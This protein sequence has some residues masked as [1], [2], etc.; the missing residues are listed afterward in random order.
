S[1]HIRVLGLKESERLL[2]PACGTGGFLVE[3]LNYLNKVFHDEKNVRPG[4]EDTQEFISLR[5]R[6]AD[7]AAN[8]LFGSDFDPFL[9]RAA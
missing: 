4:D 7:F 6:L 9:V 8:K 5:D 1:V 2:D 3:T